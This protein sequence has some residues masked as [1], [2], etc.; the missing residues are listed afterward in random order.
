MVVGRDAG[1]AGY[2][3]V[4]R[5]PPAGHVASARSTI[6]RAAAGSTSP[7]TVMIARPGLKYSR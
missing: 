7:V 3:N 5:S 4:G 1:G 2:W 6:V